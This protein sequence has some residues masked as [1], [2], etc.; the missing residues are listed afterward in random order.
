[1]AVLAVLPYVVLLAAVA[2]RWR[3]HEVGDARLTA[4]AVVRQAVAIDQRRMR[5][6]N[7]FLIALS[8]LARTLPD[9]DSLGSQI[10][11][12]VSRGTGEENFGVFTA[13]GRPLVGARPPLHP[14]ISRR[15]FFQRAV[16][17][18]QFSIDDYSV[19]RSSHIASSTVA[20]P[21][22]DEAGAPRRV[23][24]TVVDLG[25]VRDLTADALLPSG[26]TVTVFDSEGTI[27]AHQPEPGDWP[28]K[29]ARGDTLVDTALRLNAE[30]TLE[31]VA[32][33]GQRRIFAF[34]PLRDASTGRT[35]YVAAGLPSVSAT[36]QVDDIF[37]IDV[38]AFTV[39]LVIAL[40]F[41]SAG[42]NRFIVRHVH[43]LAAATRQLGRGELRGRIGAFRG[44][45]EL[46]QLAEAFDRMADGLE[47]RDR[48]RAADRDR[49]ARE[50]RRFRSL[51][52]NSAEGILLHDA[53]GRTVYVSPS[54]ARILGYEPDELLGRHARQI[55]H[56][57]DVPSL[58]A[59]LRTT[60]A[61]P[62]AVATV[63]M[64]VRRKDGMW[65][66]METSL[67]NMLD[68]PAVT[69][70]VSNYR[71]VT[72]YLDA[73]EQLR[74][75]RDELEVRVQQ[76]TVE[77]V[78]ANEALRMEVLEREHAEE[79]LQKLSGA[80][81]Q[82]ADSAF[83]TNR[84]GVIEYVNPAF[85]QLTGFTRAEAIGATPRLI[86][87]GRHG[88]PFYAAFWQSILGG[89]AVRH[90]VVNRRK[91]GTCYD[92]EQTVA[93]VR[94]VS[95]T[96]THFVATGRDI[97]QRKRTEQA[98]RRLNALLEQE[99][100]RVADLLHDEAGQ[101]LTSAHILLADVARDLPTG[102]RE[103]LEQ[104]E[105]T[106]D[107]VEEQLRR[108]SHEWHPRILTDLGLLG[109]IRFR[110]D[111][112]ARRTGV[113]SVVNAPPVLVCPSGLE[114]VMYRLVQEALTNIGKHADATSVT[115]TLESD[116]R[117][118][119]CTV[120]DDGIGFDVADTMSRTATQSLGLKGMRD[121]VEAVGGELEI[122]SAPGA[123]AELRAFFSME[124]VRAAETSP[125]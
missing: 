44:P 41:A 67:R 25:W 84:E 1:V 54:S 55:V 48:E 43:T 102:P 76:R 86:S 77:L 10:R 9:A 46:T 18:G 120:H 123:G 73:Q 124:A 57:D 24:F 68:E 45:P 81:E 66:W 2:V 14:D 78:K 88:A 111:A 50:K 113:E 114:V 52:E 26:S 33:D 42:N 115:I 20:Y 89:H 82:T 62:G 63:M 83:V 69:A 72:D 59:G 119:T 106:L 11:A 90:V 15:A 19:D 4:Q 107:Q 93:P 35:L 38:A 36:S 118:M 56:P 60:L 108:M 98:I 39:T 31:A 92:E 16:R 121:R 47:V 49:L 109:A 8:D 13:D 29:A 116:R 103:R 30:G 32:F 95:G 61:T 105:R 94:D 51:I 122:T 125:G 58:A 65:R 5:S 110:A 74:R 117:G 71:D 21:V 22:P 34:R 37:R 64:R 79:S 100:T 104:V 6:H 91:D 97:T 101:L 85:E 112:F 17:T 7:D 28:G 3:S 75:A 23:V 27:L 87:S 70:V 99:T 96:I 53:T 12:T 80:L 40:A